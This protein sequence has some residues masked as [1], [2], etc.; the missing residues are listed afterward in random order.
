MLRN[1]KNQRKDFFSAARKFEG[2]E[3]SESSTLLA[4]PDSKRTPKKDKM[5]Q[6]IEHFFC[7]ECRQETIQC[8]RGLCQQCFAIWTEVETYSDE[9]LHFVIYDIEYYLEEFHDDPYIGP[10]V[11]EDQQYYDELKLWLQI[12]LKEE[13][14]RDQHHLCMMCGSGGATEGMSD[15]CADC[16]WEEDTRRKRE[17]RCDP[18]WRL[19][20]GSKV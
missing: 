1:P 8:E 7:S 10:L 18:V 3:S 16:F 12:L 2:L 14:Y 5:E 11:K 17:R 6:V 20:T 19:L 15:M 9:T 4:S 13:D